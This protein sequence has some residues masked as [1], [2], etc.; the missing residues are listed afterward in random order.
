[1]EFTDG[2]DRWNLPTELTDGNFQL[3]ALL[4]MWALLTNSIQFSK[5]K[6]PHGLILPVA[7]M[8]QT[9]KLVFR[10]FPFARCRKTVLSKLK[11]VE[12]VLIVIDAKLQTSRRQ[13]NSNFD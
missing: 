12:N 10:E 6:L 1:M 9:F 2:I 5:I 13:I 8:S 7:F 11:I 4:Y 3:M